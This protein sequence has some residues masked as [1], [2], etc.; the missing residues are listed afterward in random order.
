MCRDELVLKQTAVGLVT[1]DASPGDTAA[2]LACYEGG[3][4]ASGAAVAGSHWPCLPHSEWR[5]LLC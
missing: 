4:D 1:L 2:L 5:V 3:P